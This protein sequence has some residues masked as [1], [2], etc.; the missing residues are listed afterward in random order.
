MTRT[1][2][3]IRPPV[4]DWTR[5]LGRLARRHERLGWIPPCAFEREAVRLGLTAAAVEHRWLAH[6]RA[7]GAT[8][9]PS[10]E[11]LLAVA[12]CPNFSE[13]IQVLRARGAS[14]P[15]PAIERELWR[16]SA[17]VLGPLHNHERR[18][19]HALRAA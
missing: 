12:R 2:S 13:A 7:L 17:L 10:S 16:A 19:R 9:R 1:A 4:G 18:R 3:R 5:C 11:D 15:S 14:A 8:W 6:A